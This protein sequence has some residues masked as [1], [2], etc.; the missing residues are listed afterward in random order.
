ML[1]EIVCSVFFALSLGAQATAQVV[2]Q[3]VAKVSVQDY[4]WRTV[5]R[6][7]VKVQ[8][9]INAEFELSKERVVP[10]H[11]TLSVP[12]SKGKLLTRTRFPLKQGNLGEMQFLSPDKTLLEFVTISVATVGGDTAEARL[13]RLFAL[14]EKQVYPSLTPPTSA[15]VLG[16]RKTKIAGHPAVEFVALF[17]V[18]KRG[19]VA[20]R[21]VGVVSP[22]ETDVV[23]F[24]Q[25]IMRAEMGLTG[26][27]ELAETFGGAMLSSLTF[28]AYRDASGNLVEF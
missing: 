15:K 28:Q 14:I 23:I 19:A 6:Q 8:M 25:Q 18:P 4:D 26:P 9:R 24:V 10:V 21:I 16:G 2:A 22:N 12:F 1:R 20:A 13:Q 7:S 3:D 27:N 11:F 17:D 5:L